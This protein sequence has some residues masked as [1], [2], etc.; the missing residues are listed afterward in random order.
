M[1]TGLLQPS[2]QAFVVVEPYIALQSMFCLVQQP[3]PPVGLS[4]PSMVVSGLSP[5]FVG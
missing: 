3:Y 1:I 4:I 5:K 2:H